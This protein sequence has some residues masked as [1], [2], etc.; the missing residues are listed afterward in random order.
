MSIYRCSECDEP[1][2]NDWHPC[3]EDPR[4][5]VDNGL[6]CE[7]CA[8]ELNIDESTA[9]RFRAFVKRQEELENE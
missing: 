9:D 5:T 2:D 8:S 7:D 3:I 6:L 1:K 4:P